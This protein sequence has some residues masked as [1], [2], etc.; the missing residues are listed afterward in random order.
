MLDKIGTT[1]PDEVTAL[2]SLEVRFVTGEVT[3]EELENYI[4]TAYAPATAA[5][6]QEFTGFMQANPARF[7]D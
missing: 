4:T 3:F 1:C 6:A 7:E 5:I 2:N